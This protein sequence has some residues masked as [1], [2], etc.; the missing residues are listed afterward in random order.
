MRNAPTQVESAD[1]LDRAES[2]QTTAR[3]LTGI[4]AAALVTGG[5]LL[6]FDLASGPS[7]S[8]D[9]ARRGL[10]IDVGCSGA[11]CGVV[12]SGAF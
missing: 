9:R 2:R 6:Y 11:G 10:P 1:A 7:S 5:V 12:A 4:G 3:V 8:T